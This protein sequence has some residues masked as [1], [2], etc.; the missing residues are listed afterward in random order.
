MRSIQK[1]AML[2]VSLGALI[3]PMPVFAQSAQPAA[4]AADSEEVTIIVQARRKDE[5]VQDVPVV[6]NPVTAEEIG[7][8]NLRKFEDIAS[9]VPGLSL[10][11]NQNGIGAV[12]TV[13]GI[14]FDVNVSGNNGT[15]QFYQN[16]IPVPAGLLFNA[17]FDVGQIEVLRGPQ[18][19]LKGRSAPSGAITLYTHK[20]DLSEVGGNAEV[21]INDLHGYQTK[22]ALNVPVIA[23]KLGVRIAGVVSDGQGNR[24]HDV[25]NTT[26]L[27]DETQGIRA[28]V[29]ADP[30]DGVLELNFTYQGVN[31][32]VVGFGQSESASEVI[33]GAFGGPVL[34]RAK[35]RLSAIG[36][37]LRNNQ[38][39]QT[40]DWQAKLS[41]IGQQLTYNGGRAVQTLQAIA[42][43]DIGGVF[44]VDSSGANQFAQKTNTVSHNTSHEVR[45][46]NEERIAGIFDYVAGALFAK[47]DSNTNFGSVTGIALAPPFSTPPRLVNIAITP[48]N[49][50][51]NNKETSFFGNVTAHIGDAFEVAGG[52]RR[53]KYED[54][55]GLAV[56]GTINPAFTRNFV[57]RKTI[58]QASAKYQVT[59]DLMV[60]AS[61]GSSFRPST[62]AI[63]GPTGGLSALQLS[64][65]STAAETSKSYEVGFKSEFF[66]RTVRFNMTGFYQKFQN[67]PYRSTSGV[68]AIDRTNSAAG[69]VTAFNYVAAVPVTVKGVEGELSY[70][71]NKHFSIGSVFS[72]SK[73][74]ISNGT[75]PC[76]DLNGDKIPDTGGQPT[77]AALQ[78][79]VGAN[80]ISSCTANFNSTLAA[81]FSTSVQSEYN[82]PLSDSMDGYVRGLYSYKGRSDND[83]TNIYDNIKSYGLLNLYAGVRDPDGAW[84]VSLFAK[85]VTNTFRV[86][87][88]SNGVAF[89]PL[90]GGIPLGGPVTSSGPLSN[91]Y[92]SGANDSG[93][94]VTEP[95]EFGINLKVAFGSR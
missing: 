40:Y 57:E 33:P 12:A 55:S 27:N 65:L 64:Y 41:L 42:P 47:G 20:P 8:L 70:T 37:P 73:G 23:D 17:L 11:A 46:Q 89:T 35:D 24:V 16:D 28:S 31:R 84:E 26:K 48:I 13:R 34:I 88:R 59:R 92:F 91:G 18:G 4:D 14:N 94:V 74:T 60:Y 50:F 86:L 90:R 22:G 3:A 5:S 38:K 85:N 78:A 51:G 1:I 6:V 52:V 67:Y 54:N 77:L 71:P 43:T 63:G 87:K 21:T 80:N 30:F 32:K 45:L 25:V 7:K 95:R 29:A 58:Y 93:L 68:F 76:L 61:T 15:V 81:R 72:Y 39:F 44:A 19:T 75:V 36:T 2:G 66:D 53:I 82:L 49:R 69:T 9:V 79:V 62:V 56:N 83:P 10:S